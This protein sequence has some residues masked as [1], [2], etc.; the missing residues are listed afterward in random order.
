MDDLRELTPKER[1]NEMIG[2]D[3]VPT[4]S[5]VQGMNVYNGNAD[6]N[7]GS[8]IDRLR[9]ATG[10]P[11]YMYDAGEMLCYY[12]GLADIHTYN[13]YEA[14]NVIKT[15]L[16]KDNLLGSFIAKDGELVE[17]TTTTLNPTVYYPTLDDSFQYDVTA[18]VWTDTATQTIDGT[19][20]DLTSL[21]YTSTQVGN[22]VTIDYSGSATYEGGNAI[23]HYCLLEW[24]NIT[25]D[26]ATAIKAIFDRTGTSGVWDT[27]NQQYGDYDAVNTYRITVEMLL[28]L[29]EFF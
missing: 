20:Y 4:H 28:R 29:P 25:G 2:I 3:G 12:L 6:I 21:P 9:T 18:I 24:E 11:A 5:K 1:I 27:D 19:E 10:A 16:P 14:W 7:S 26:N 15:L 13:E 23:P 17:Q 22:I 8:Y